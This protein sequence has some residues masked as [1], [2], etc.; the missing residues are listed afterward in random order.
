MPFIESV[1]TT[2]YMIAVNLAPFSLSEPNDRRRP[3]AGPFKNLSALLLSIGTWGRSTKTLS[4]SRW[5]NSERR[6]LPS[7]AS[8][9][10][11]AS[12]RAASANRPSSASFS[13]PCAASNAG[14]WRLPPGS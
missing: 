7:R 9:G 4:P 1:P 14:V 10:R 5:F 6:A 3:M 12:S 13:A 11:P 8:S 2:E